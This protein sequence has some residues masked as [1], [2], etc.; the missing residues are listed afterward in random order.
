MS[1]LSPPILFK[2]L[3][4]ETRARI[5]LLVMQ[6]TELCVCELTCAL[7]ESQPKISRH[8]A[9]LR[10]VGLLG[11]RRQGQWV[12]YHLHPEL[13]DWVRVMLEPVLV[14]NQSWLLNDTN[15]LAVMGDRPARKAFCC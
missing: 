10:S 8:L 1:D 5:V 11:D 4:D 2:A 13:P 12:Y 7:G 3:A 9:L 14:A 15:R 6:E